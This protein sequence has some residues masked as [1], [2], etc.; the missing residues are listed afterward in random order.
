MGANN[1][2]TIRECRK[3][4]VENPLSEFAVSKKEKGGLRAECKSCRAKIDKHNRMMKIETYRTK[5]RL[6]CQK[7][8]KNPD[9]RRR[10]RDQKDPVKETARQVLRSAVA[11]GKIIKPTK[12]QR[13][14]Q[15]KKLHGHH[16]D[17]SKPLDVLWL[18]AVC[19]AAA[20][21]ELEHETA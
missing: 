21:K 2:P 13:C 10:H 5:E 17:Y 18:C 3:C 11:D 20:H 7:R 4:K 16:E 15:E 6:R 14:Y 12:C 19:H 9:N 1:P 8:W